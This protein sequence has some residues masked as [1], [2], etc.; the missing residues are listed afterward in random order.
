MKNEAL[1]LAIKA[2]KSFQEATNGLYKGEFD[3]EI[4]K[5]EEALA[6]SAFGASSKIKMKRPAESDYNS[7]VAYTR[8]LEEYCDSLEAALPEQE[9]VSLKIKL[10]VGF[11]NAGVS[12]NNFF[13]ADTNDSKNWDT[14][15]FPLPKGNWVIKSVKEN[16][17]TLVN[18]A[19]LPVREQ[20][21]KHGECFGGECIY[22]PAQEPVVDKGFPWTQKHVATPQVFGAMPS[23]IPPPQHKWVN[24]STEDIL[25]LLDEHNLYGSKL[26]ELI[27][28]TESKVKS[29]NV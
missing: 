18:E 8:A 17:V 7:H 12:V 21:Q 27:R 15:K 3:E 24:L 10:P 23:N 14:I 22:P 6:Q 2:M 1:R 28:A 19:P 25:T 13:T 5:C 29:N 9:L 20:C 4:A 16:V 11:M 26:V